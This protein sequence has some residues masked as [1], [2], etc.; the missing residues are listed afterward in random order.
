MIK[1][2]LNIKFLSLIQEITG[3]EKLNLQIDVEQFSIMDLIHELDIKF[4]QSFKDLIINKKNKG[5]KPEILIFIDNKEI[6]SLQNLNTL[7]SDGD[8]IVFLSS[9]HGGYENLS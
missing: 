9:I 6:Q 5:I 7:L 3:I 1:I 2:I 8:Q 4:G